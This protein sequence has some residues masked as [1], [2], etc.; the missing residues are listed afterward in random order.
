MD[1]P[2]VAAQIALVGTVIGVGLAMLFEG[3][4]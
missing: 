2:T 4:P 1:W 3:Q